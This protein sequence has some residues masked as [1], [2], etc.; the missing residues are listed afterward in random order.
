MWNLPPPLG[1]HGLDERKP[2]TVYMRNLPHWRQ[3]G[4]TYFVTFR[5]ADSL[6]QVK[7]DE[8]RDL[9]RGWE[10]QH[11]LPRSEAVLHEWARLA[12]ERIECWLDQGMGKCVL[13]EPSVAS[14]VSSAFHYHDDDRY[15]LDC[16]VIMPNHAH[17]VLRPLRAE[18][19]VEEIVGSWKKY[20]ARQI[21]RI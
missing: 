10:R 5:L 17:V 4:A 14:L 11:P 16:Y 13:Q 21:N 19:P 7:L 6:P 18:Y 9:R 3:D 2:L 12:S 20:S 15:E 1:F 8:L